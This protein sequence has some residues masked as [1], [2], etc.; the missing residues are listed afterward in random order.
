[1]NCGKGVFTW[2]VQGPVVSNPLE[3]VVGCST[4]SNL[5]EG[6]AITFPDIN[7]LRAQYKKE[8]L[9][10]KVTRQ[11]KELGKLTPKD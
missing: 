2:T 4:C 3:C 11:M 8:H 7:E 9:W 5:C 6:N 10:A 1:M